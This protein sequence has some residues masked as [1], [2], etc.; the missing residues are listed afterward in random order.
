MERA[1]LVVLAILLANVAWAVALPIALT[2]PPAG[3]AV[4]L[5][6]L[7]VAALAAALVAVLW[8]A[9]TPWVEQRTRA[10]C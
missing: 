2:R 4:L 1:R 5:L 3:A 10:G 8:A 7:L 9:V 6:W